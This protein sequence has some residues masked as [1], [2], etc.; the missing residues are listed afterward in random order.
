M[1]HDCSVD[2]RRGRI[3]VFDGST[4]WTVGRVLS[5]LVGTETEAVLYAGPHTHHGIVRG[6]GE[7]LVTLESGGDLIAVSLPEITSFH[8]LGGARGIGTGS[9]VIE[10]EDDEPDTSSEDEPVVIS[11][12]PPS[13]T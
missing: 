5:R 9:W 11:S 1:R 4:T 2:R 6:V 13:A 12:E 3:V 7:Y 8:V 10:D